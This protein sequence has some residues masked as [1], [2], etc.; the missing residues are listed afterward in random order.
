MSE[1]AIQ[2]TDLQKSYGSTEAVRGI[3]FDVE[4]GRI[5]LGGVE[6]VRLVDNGLDLSRL[7]RQVQPSEDLLALD[8]GAQVL[9]L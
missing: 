8:G 4:R 6:W 1:I 3:S 7:D 9:D 2:V 5:S